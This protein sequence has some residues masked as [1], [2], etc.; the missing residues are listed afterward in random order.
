MVEQV[1]RRLRRSAKGHSE[2]ASMRA[3][4]SMQR[5]EGGLAATTAGAACFFPACYPSPAEN[6]DDEELAV[7]VFRG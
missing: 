6:G 1:P 4:I 7:A 5:F 3:A 2:V